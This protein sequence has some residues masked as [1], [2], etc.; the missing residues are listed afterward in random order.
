MITINH[1][2]WG[3]TI[4]RVVGMPIEGAVAGSLPDI[5]TVPVFGYYLK[6]K[7]IQPENSPQWIKNI[8]EVFHNWFFAILLISS[9]YIFFPKFWIIGTAYLWHVVEDAFVHTK[10]ATRFLFP[11][12]K[13]KI[14]KYSANDNKW[15]QVVDLILILLVN[16]WI[17]YFKKS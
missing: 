4:G 14:Q 11:F 7:K 5:F 15:I 8:Y 13:G 9:L 2:L 6:L 16:I 3:A 1:A 10:M 17:S 12:W